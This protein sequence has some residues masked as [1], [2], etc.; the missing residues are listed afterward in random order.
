MYE[1][2]V[3]LVVRTTA[4]QLFKRWFD[5]GSEEFEVVSQSKLSKK[6]GYLFVAESQYKNGVDNRPAKELHSEITL[7][8]DIV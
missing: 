6:N 3:R 4:C 5:P 7:E 2:P 1:V 8:E